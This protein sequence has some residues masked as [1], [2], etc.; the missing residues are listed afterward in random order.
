MLHS[1]RSMIGKKILATDAVLG[2]V[3]DIYFDDLTWTAR[4]AVVET[5]TWLSCRQVLISLISL[6]LQ[7]WDSL[8]LIVNLTCEQVRNSPDI[9]TKRPV[10]RQNEILLHEYY[11][12]SNY[13][14]NG[15]QGTFGLTSFP[16]FDDFI[17]PDSA[18]RERN[19]DPHLRSI[20][21]VTGY[22][23]HA[24]DGIIGE[25]DGLMVENDKWNIKFIIVTTGS[26]LTSKKVLVF[27]SIISNV[28]WSK[29][30]IYVDC[31]KETIKETTRYISS[32]SKI[33]DDWTRVEE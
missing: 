5:G 1:L 29:A 23:V 30:S 16:L 17:L 28:N 10:F 9:D 12:W 14:D 8:V 6:G 21:Q 11:Q 18:Y 7:D 31:S 15:Y 25:V 13:W 22:T 2:K 26:W 24:N 27:S 33:P 20:C 32:D 4:Y 19:D 3:I